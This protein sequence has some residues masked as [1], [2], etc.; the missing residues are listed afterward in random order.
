MSKFGDSSPKLVTVASMGHYVGERLA[1]KGE[2]CTVRYVGGIGNKRGDW[3]GVEWDDPRKG[4]HDGSYEGVKYFQSENSL[5]FMRQ[6]I[7]KKKTFNSKTYYQPQCQS[8]ML[9]I[10]NDL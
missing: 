6:S 8:M 7:G 10:S 5:L 4:K 1:F 3:L 2:R 9:I